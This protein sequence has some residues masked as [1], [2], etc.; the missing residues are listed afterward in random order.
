MTTRKHQPPPTKFL[1]NGTAQAKPVAPSPSHTP[2]PTKFAPSAGVQAKPAQK[3]NHAPPPTQF[4]S[5]GTAQAKWAQGVRHLPPPTR[6]AAQAAGPVQGK[7]VVGGR[8]DFRPRPGSLPASRP[9]TVQRMSKSDEE[10]DEESTEA[11]IVRILKKR[12]IFIST[13]EVEFYAS[14]LL[15]NPPN[16]LVP[17][18]GHHRALK[19]SSVG[20]ISSVVWRPP[21]DASRMRVSPF[22]GPLLEE[23]SSM[24]TMGPRPLIGSITWQS[25]TIDQ[26]MLTNIPERPSLASVMGGSASKLSGVDNSEWLHLRAHSLGGPDTPV[27]LVAGPH[28]L[29]TAMIP[30]ERFVRSK[31]RQGVVV[32]Y[33]V[34]FFSEQEGSVSYVHHVQIDIKLANGIEGSWTLEVNSQKRDEFI[35]GQ[36]LAEIE[37]AVKQ[38]SE[39]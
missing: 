20:L 12:N 7:A 10:E 4:P 6:F 17:I 22:N 8:N 32:D 15:S 26:Q 23:E 2:P 27:N 25:A 28:S 24:L 33:D 19:M 29:N 37:D 11:N 31:V 14:E 39:K 3:L 1:R 5:N 9:M 21:S 13:D 38:F 34:T 18:K 35:N 16:T 36:V 30:F